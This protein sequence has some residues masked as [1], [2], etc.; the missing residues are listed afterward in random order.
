MTWSAT[1]P[2]HHAGRKTE[3]DREEVKPST[4]HGS[5]VEGEKMEF[6]KCA[7]AKRH[8]K[9]ERDIEKDRRRETGR[10][11]PGGALERGRDG[12]YV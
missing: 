10:E 1:A 3:S 11:P 5:A 6:R 8:R 4:A 7:V 12:S 2:A 9:S